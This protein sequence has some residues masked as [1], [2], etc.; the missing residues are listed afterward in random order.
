MKSEQIQSLTRQYP[1][2]MYAFDIGVLRKRV[3]YLKDALPKGVKICYAVKANNFIIKELIEDVDRFEICSPGEAYVCQRL[4]VPAEKMVISG[5]YKTPEFIEDLVAHHPDVG[6]YTVESMEHFRL[7][8]HCSE[9]YGRKLPVLLRLTSGNQFGL[10]E[11]DLRQIVRDHAEVL[12]IKGIQYY[13]GTQKH[14]MKKLK[15]ELEHLD[16]LM[17]SL[18]ADYGFVTRE[19]EFGPGFQVCYFRGEEY[20]EDGFLAEFSQLLSQ[21]QYQTKITLEM[22]RAIAASCGTYLTRVVDRKVNKKQNYAIVDGGIHHLVYFGQSMAMKHPMYQVLPEREATEDEFW[23]LC[24]S[25]CTVNDILVKQLPVKNLQMGDV[26]A[27]ENTGA[28]CMIEGISLF[29]SRELPRVVL[30]K[31]DG[32]TILVRNEVATDTINTPNYERKQ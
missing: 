14:S 12:D 4:D 8:R 29:L 9:A 30:V 15:R 18:Q 22:G 32:D 19:L 2:P 26:F 11:S 31:E 16:E 25:L 1:T 28:Y 3:Q 20:D 13:S 7:L 23:N 10:D 21:M 6:I 27:F 5:V 24:G 17:Q